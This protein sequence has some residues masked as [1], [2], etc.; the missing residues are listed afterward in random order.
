M[1]LDIVQN[2]NSA[3]NLWNPCVQGFNT[4]SMAVFGRACLKTLNLPAVLTPVICKFINKAAF[5]H[6]AGARDRPPAYDIVTGAESF[7]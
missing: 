3:R 2:H 4:G 6:T 5:T 1:S 7:Q